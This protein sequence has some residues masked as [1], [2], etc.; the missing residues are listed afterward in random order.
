VLPRGYT[1]GNTGTY[2]VAFSE[3]NFLLKN[4]TIDFKGLLKVGTA[5]AISMA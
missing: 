5:S 2:F 3:V 4:Q 1:S